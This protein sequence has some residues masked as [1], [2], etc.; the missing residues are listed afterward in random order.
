M[1]KNKVDEL[2]RP[3][4]VGDLVC[5]IYPDS[6]N[7]FIYSIVVDENGGIYNGR[8]IIFS[9]RLLYLITNPDEVEK[10]KYNELMDSYNEFIEFIKKR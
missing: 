8:Y 5:C 4:S 7:E 2:G 6:R 1:N 3:I 9:P 10:M